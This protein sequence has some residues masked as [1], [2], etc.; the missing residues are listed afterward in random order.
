MKDNIKGSNIF[1]HFKAEVKDN[2][3]LNKNHFLLT[4]SP[5]VENIMMPAGGQFY[6]L[7][8]S[9][10]YDPLMKRPFSVFRF[11]ENRIQILYRVRGKGTAI[12]SRI[13]SGCVLDVIGPLGNS[14]PM[15]P[16]KY[17]PLIV[18]GGIGIASLF[19]L[20][21][22]LKDK[23]VVIYGAKTKSELCMLDD[24][25]GLVSGLT[26]C[27]D[28]GSYGKKATVLEA[29][30]DIAYDRDYLLYSCGPKEMLRKL[31]QFTLKKGLKGYISLEETMACGLGA[32]LGCAV[33]TKNGYKRVCKEGTVF[34]IQDIA[35]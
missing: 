11:S 10:L 17:T 25:L 16:K 5:L 3:E 24:L 20:I 34:P 12:M 18:A 7:G 29:L 19:S 2:I 32:C 31:A 14:Y 21:H 1:R 35:W 4:L 9:T 6:M 8:V 30:N 27:T 28:D 26:V 23:S 22:C 13:N 15:P 33:K